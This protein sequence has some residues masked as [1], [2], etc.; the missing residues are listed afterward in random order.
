MIDLPDV[1]AK[2]LR[3]AGFGDAKTRKLSDVSKGGIAVRR[4]PST[5]R[6]RYYDG[7]RDVAYVVQVVVARESE[8][9]AIEECEAIARIVP[10][11]DL[12]SENGSY[13]MTSCDAYTDPQEITT[14]TWE[15]KFQASITTKG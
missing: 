14:G 3:E 1:L 13:D 8:E 10:T 5:T 4:Y 9:Q 7:S 15:A 6:A 11:L 12:R 2:R